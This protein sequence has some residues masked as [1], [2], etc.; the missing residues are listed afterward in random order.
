MARLAFL[1]SRVSS[2]E[3]LRGGG[4]A[5]QR[6]SAEEFC[7]RHGWTLDARSYSDLGL[8]AY[9]GAN[10]KTGELAAFI[11]AV[12]QGAIPRD[13]VLLCESHDRLSRD[14]VVL[15]LDAFRKLLALGITVCTMSDGKVF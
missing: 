3:Q 5:R 15:A 4:I 11:H 13:S 9:K 2:P 7:R 12:E 6:Q 14:R 1:Y 8:S 10:V